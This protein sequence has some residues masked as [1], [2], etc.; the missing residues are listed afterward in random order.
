MDELHWLDDGPGRGPCLVLAHGAGAPM[1]SEWMED[2]THLLVA[3][4]VRVLRFEFPYMAGRR[5]DGKRRGPDRAPKLEEAWRAAIASAADRTSRAIAEIAIG[6][7]S[8]GGRI[9]SHV[10]DELGVAALVCFGYPFH[11]PGKPEKLRTAH[12][13]GLATRT[14]IVQGERD[15]FGTREEIAQYELAPAIEVFYSGDG[16]HSLKPR[17]RSGRSLEENLHEAAQRTASFLGA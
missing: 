14:L 15:T 17:K 2:L 12:L 9:A 7:K 3:E 5:I 16:D 6:G 13:A 1:D 8:M 11:P 4:G 10:A